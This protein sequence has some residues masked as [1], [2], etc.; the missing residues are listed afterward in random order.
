MKELCDLAVDDE[1]ILYLKACPD[2][3]VMGK[4]LQFGN[5]RDWVSVEREGYE[6]YVDAEDICMIGAKIREVHA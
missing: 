4:V 3:P 1:I 6:C 5:D 2:Y